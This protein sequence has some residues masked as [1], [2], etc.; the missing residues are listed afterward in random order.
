MVSGTS[1]RGLY[2]VT[3]KTTSHG[4]TTY[5]ICLKQLDIDVI[6]CQAAAHAACH[7][8]PTQGRDNSRGR[9]CDMR[10][11]CYVDVV[12]AHARRRS[13]E[14]LR[15]AMRSSSI[16]YTWPA[17]T[18]RLITDNIAFDAV[19]S[20]SHLDTWKRHGANSWMR[21]GGVWY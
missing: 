7:V 3:S 21:Q 14:W 11:K 2:Q 8:R 16:G 9:A 1:E 19:S 20:S 4:I 6:C 18:G 17:T 12:L 5:I 13:D 15:E 10:D